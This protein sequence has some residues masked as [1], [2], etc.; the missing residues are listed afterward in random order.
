MKIVLFIP[1]KLNNQRLPGKNTMDL[2]GKPLCSYL[3]ST[4]SRLSSID[5]KYVYC[6]DESIIPFIPAGLQFF[7][8]PTR[9]D[10]YDTKGLDIIEQFVKDVDADIYI[11]THVTQPFVRKESFE[12]AI[13]NVKNGNYD[14]AFSAVALQDYFWSGN[15]PLNF[16]PSNIIRTQDLEPLL[17]E[18]GAFYIFTKDVFTKLHRRVGNNP[19]IQIIDQFE[20]VDIDT[21]E[22]F[23]FAKVVG[24]F[25]QQRCKD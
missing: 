13:L 16:D 14:S 4:V 15:Q 2:N 22:D 12:K 3:F 11:L 6:S 25:L 19:Y 1:I 24:H 17:M 5:K 23:E 21:K 8:R 20:A 18:T 9:L 10:N 7:K